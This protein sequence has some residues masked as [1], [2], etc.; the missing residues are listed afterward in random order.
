MESIFKIEFEYFLA[1]LNLLQETIISLNDDYKVLLQLHI[2]V[3][4]RIHENVLLP[5]THPAA[6]MCTYHN[7]GPIKLKYEHLSNRKRK[8]P[9]LENSLNSSMFD[10]GFFLKRFID[11]H[12]LINN[13][14]D[15]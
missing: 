7:F 9:T 4:H 1:V 12:R 8:E 5:S 11:V 15:E 2:Q 6:T 10:I 14:V 13:S 3:S